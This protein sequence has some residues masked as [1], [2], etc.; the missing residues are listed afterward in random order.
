[1]NGKTITA[2][3]ILGEVLTLERTIVSLKTKLLNMMPPKYGSDAWWEESD[4][5]A[6]EN[7][8]AGKGKKF[9]TYKEAVRYL[10]S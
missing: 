7:I 5:K 2:G 3:D 1:M 9:D 8:K 4:K 6:L 10:N